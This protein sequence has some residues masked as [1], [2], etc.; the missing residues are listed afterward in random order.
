MNICDLNWAY[1]KDI[2]VAV[3]GAGVPS[4]VAWLIFT[5]WRKQ[6]ASEVIANEARQFIVKLAKLQSL[7]SEIHKII[8]DSEGYDSAKV[9]FIDFKETRSLLN[10]SANL[11]GESLKDKSISHFST[12]VMAQALLFEKDIEAFKND[13]KL[14]SQVRMINPDDAKIISDIFLDYA[15]YKEPKKTK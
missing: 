5:K 3:I 2:F 7:Q 15:L 8:Y 14:L 4:L 13:E 12:T 9:E 6:K 10:D 11:L 1:L